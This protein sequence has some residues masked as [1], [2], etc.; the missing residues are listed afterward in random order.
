M[1]A[2]S[3]LRT[4]NFFATRWTLKGAPWR[5]LRGKS[6]GEDIDFELLLATAGRA[7]SSYSQRRV[8]DAVSRLC[9]S[10]RL[11]DEEDHWIC[12]CNG[13]DRYL[14]DLFCRDG[15]VEA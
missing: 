11:F 12:M 10:E 1:D 5:G 15:S 7:R 6:S 4:P 8:M 9:E 14:F 3:S 13:D 2:P